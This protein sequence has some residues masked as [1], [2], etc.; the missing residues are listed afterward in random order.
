MAADVFVSVGRTFNAEQEAF[1]S[2]V[3]QCL[4]RNGMVARTVGRTSFGAAKPLKQIENLMHTCQGVVVIALARMHIEKGIDRSGGS[5]ERRLD[6]IKLP[7]VWNQIETAM[8]YSLGKPLLVIM[9]QGV[10]REG[11]LDLNHDWY[12]QRVSLDVASLST[13]EFCGVFDDWKRLVQASRGRRIPL[14]DIT[15]WDLLRSLKFSHAAAIAGAMIA[16]VGGAATLGRQFAPTPQSPTQPG[17]AN[18]A[19]K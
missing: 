14:D 19:N 10:H 1:V 4:T 8:G 15:V 13:P 9:E 2:A 17:T 6:G 7:T 3:E 12:V 11:L 18:V 5:D 16:I